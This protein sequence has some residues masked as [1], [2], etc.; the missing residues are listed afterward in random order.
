M[1]TV[2]LYGPPGVGK[3]TV[4]G[5]LAALTGFKFVYSHLSTNLASAVFPFLSEPWLRLLVRV[6]RDVLAEAVAEGVDVVVTGAYNGEPRGAELWRSMLEPVTAAGGSVL[7]VQLTCTR[8][9]LF[10]RVQNDSRLAYDKLTDARVLAEISQRSDLFARL[11]I[12]P[13]LRIDSTHLSPSEAAA[14]I[15][16]HYRLLPGQAGHAAN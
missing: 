9:E 2:F 5:E 11:P 16:A 3:Q 1:R 10:A 6:R 7:G 13:Q 15:A 12:E 4:G 8:E 14:R